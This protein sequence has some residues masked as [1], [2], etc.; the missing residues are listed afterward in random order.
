M[1]KTIKTESEKKIFLENI[2]KGVTNNETIDYNSTKLWYKLSRE[3]VKKNGGR[4]LFNEGKSLFDILREFYPQNNLYAWLFEKG[5]VPSNYWENIENHKLYINWYLELKGLKVN[6]VINYEECYKIKNEELCKEKGGSLINLKYDFSV[7][8]LLKATIEYHWLPWKFT[9][10]PNNFWS[11]EYKK[12]NAILYLN[13]LFDVLEFSSKK[14]FYKLKK[15]HFVNNYGA[16]LLNVFNSKIMDMLNFAFPNDDT[17][18]WQFWRFGQV[19]KYVWDIISNQ[20]EFMDYVHK[21]L[22]IKSQEEMYYVEIDEI[23]YYGG[24]TLTNNIYS[25][26]R[27][28]LY[29]SIFPELI[30]EKDKFFKKTDLC[31][32]NGCC[33]N[34]FNRSFASHPYSN[35]LSKKKQKPANKVNRYS[36][37]K[38]LFECHM[39]NHE[40]K[41]SPHEIQG[42]S[43]CPYCRKVA[44]FL[45]GDINCDWCYNNSLA[46]IPLSNTIVDKSINLL[47][48]N[49]HAKQSFEC[50]CEKCNNIFK[51]YAYQ[52][53]SGSFCGFCKKKTEEK[54]FEF[55]KILVIPQCKIIEIVREY[56]KDWCKG[57]FNNKLPYDFC[58][59]LEYNNKQFNIIIEV[60][61][62]QHFRDIKNWC[63]YEKQHIRDIYKIKRALENN[64]SIIRIYQPD[65]WFDNIDW[66]TEIQ[67]KINQILHTKNPSI[68]F[69]S[70]LNIYDNFNFNL[71]MELN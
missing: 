4:S 35:M 70:N 65:I 47:I 10:A 16:G 24:I 58:I 44:P 41:L 62:E 33:H 19:Q 39:C 60:D 66:K 51:K 48:I 55:L 2:L 68:H 38:L 14:D 50:K 20:R 31:G 29:S 27:Y 3:I 45:C 32:I 8:N 63:N 61:G 37:E 30:W 69:I 42:G 36:D 54:T 6:D 57:E 11:G 25:N 34:C 1:K 23:N 5:N 18:K 21:K 40:F 13:W 12:E 67:I 28:N 59:V 22:L 56:K 49:K 53:S 26:N 15:N 52:L 43:Y 17:W 9:N 71:K 46:S 7:Y 64:N